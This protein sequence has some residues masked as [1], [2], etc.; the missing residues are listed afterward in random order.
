MRIS[1]QESSLCSLLLLL[2]IAP[3]SAIA[4]PWATSDSTQSLAVNRQSKQPYHRSHSVFPQLIWLRDTAIEKIFGI[5][6]KQEAT[7]SKENGHASYRRP[8]SAQLPA[9]LLAKYGG[10]VV[11]RF[12][13]TTTQEEAALMEAADVLFLDV[14]AFTNNWADIRLAEDDVR[15]H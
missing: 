5:R 3:V 13:L 1:L 11:L 7:K 2:S 10:D 14:W 9:T 12:N 6:P 4:V 8:S 15:I